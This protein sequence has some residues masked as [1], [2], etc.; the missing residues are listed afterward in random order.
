MIDDKDGVGT[1]FRMVTEDRGRRM[2]FR[3]V[4]TEWEPPH[5]SAARLEG[6]HFNID[7]DYRFEDLGGRT[8]V[9]QHSIVQGKGFVKVMFFLFGWAMKKSGCK[10]QENEL[11]SLK[12]HC[13]ALASESA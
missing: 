13:E 12:S 8:R 3:G 11:A 9:T 10:A 1:T 7:V 4:V 6:D 5:R 2:E